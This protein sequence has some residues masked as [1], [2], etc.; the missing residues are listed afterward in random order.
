ML[1]MTTLYARLLEICRDMGI[2]TPR[3]VDIQRLTGLSSGR[4][5]QIKQAREAGRINEETLRKLTKHGYSGDW[6]QEGRGSKLIPSP[7]AK[8][9]R[10]DGRPSTVSVLSDNKQE[11]MAYPLGELIET[12]KLLSRDDQILLLG[13]A[14][15]MA[16]QRPA[17]K[18]NS[19]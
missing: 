13:R 14:K 15:E 5:T 1:N 7:P 4:V 11:A 9:K 12:A 17:A 3:G 19:A 8:G 18:A 10:D 16:A 2:E 6:I